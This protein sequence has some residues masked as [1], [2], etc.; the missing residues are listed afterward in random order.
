MGAK[1]T[2]RNG[3]SAN[4]CIFDSARLLMLA[5]ERDD[6]W[7]SGRALMISSRNI[8]AAIIAEFPFVSPLFF[9]LSP[10]KRSCATTVSIFSFFTMG[11]RHDKMAEG[12]WWRGHNGNML[13]N[14]GNDL[15]VVQE[16][17]EELI[18]SDQTTLASTRVRERQRATE[19]VRLQCALLTLPALVYFQALC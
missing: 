6:W 15:R 4:E 12:W 8:R 11:N 3:R 17:F 9:F 7:N 5:Y 13:A 18:R 19:C 2:R 10:S 14:I 16:P 1:L